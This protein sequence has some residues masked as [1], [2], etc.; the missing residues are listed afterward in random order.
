MHVHVS[1]IFELI[2]RPLCSASLQL[3]LAASACLET[4]LEMV[5][6]RASR[7]LLQVKPIC[8]SFVCHEFRSDA[9][10]LGMPTLK[11][12][13]FIHL[14][15]YEQLLAGA[16][17]SLDKEGNPN[18]WHGGLLALRCLVAKVCA[19]PSLTRRRCLLVVH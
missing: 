3:R 12:T 11:L 19:G 17:L 5:A 14:Q 2:W 1:S 7:F 9:R 18:A 13:S 6:P 10:G 16:R 15:W 4:C 8:K